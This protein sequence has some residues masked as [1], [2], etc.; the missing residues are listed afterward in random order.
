M[1]ANDN[2]VFH[3]T[4]G[5]LVDSNQIV[6]LLKHKPKGRP[7]TKWSKSF[8][9]KS[10]SKGKNGLGV[11]KQ[12]LVI[13]VINV[14]YVGKIVIIAILVLNNK[15]CLIMYLQQRLIDYLV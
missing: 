11:N 7:A 12:F 4:K 3:N 1:I 5:V 2:R 10:S 13:R 8:F 14:V 9:E 6:D 15:L